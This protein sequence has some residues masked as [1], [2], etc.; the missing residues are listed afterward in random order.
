MYVCIMY[1]YTH[2]CTHTYM[3][4][5]LDILCC[6]HSCSS[7]K[8]LNYNF[9]YLSTCFFTLFEQNMWNTFKPNSTTCQT[10]NVINCN[11]K[12][13][14]IPLTLFYRGTHHITAHLDFC[15]NTFEFK[16]NGRYS[17][18][19]GSYIVYIVYFHVFLKSM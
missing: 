10:W 1:T 12:C 8:P 16:T 2:A 9:S 19:K 6:S 13:S 11:I 3:Y 18:F 7:C 5:C 4:I 17:P 15:S 14:G